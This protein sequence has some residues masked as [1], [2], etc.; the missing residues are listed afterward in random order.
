MYIDFLKV[1]GIDYDCKYKEYVSK[2]WYVI[3][4]ILVNIYCIVFLVR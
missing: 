3:C 2:V 1:V 4:V